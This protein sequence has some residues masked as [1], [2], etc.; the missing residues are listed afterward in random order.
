[1][2]DVCAAYPRLAHASKRHDDGT[3]GTVLDVL[4]NVVLQIGRIGQS[5]VFPHDEQEVTEVP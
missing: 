3:L 5:E 4:G 2:Y 1:M